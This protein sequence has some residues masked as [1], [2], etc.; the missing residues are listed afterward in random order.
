MRDM[1]KVNV[2]NGTFAEQVRNEA[3]AFRTA[4]SRG[5]SCLRR[6]SIRAKSPRHSVENPRTVSRDEIKRRLLNR[7]HGFPSE[8]TA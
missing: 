7:F 4:Q 5:Y 1:W 2:P 3:S 8:T 6:I